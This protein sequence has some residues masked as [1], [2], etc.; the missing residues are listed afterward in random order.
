MTIRQASSDRVA[1]ALDL[2]V[3]LQQIGGLIRRG[4]LE[5]EHGLVGHPE[6]PGAA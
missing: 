3:L 1:Y 2:S 4:G 6:I 5:L